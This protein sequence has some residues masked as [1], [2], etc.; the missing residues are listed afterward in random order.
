M[1]L[2]VLEVLD[3]GRQSGDVVVQVDPAFDV[4]PANLRN[5]RE[6][7]LR[8]VFGW[9]TVAQRTL[10]RIALHYRSPDYGGELRLSTRE[11]E[12]TCSTITNV[13]ITETTVEETIMLDF[14]IAKAGIR[15]VS[16]LLPASMKDARL[17]VPLLGHKTIEPVSSQPLAPIRVRLHLQDEVMG[18]LRVLVEDDHLLTPGTHHVAIPVVETG[19]TKHRYVALESAGRDEVVIEEA[20]GLEALTRNQKEWRV[21]ADMLGDGLTQ[22]YVAGAGEPRLAFSTKKRVAVKTAGARIGLAE[23]ILVLDEHGTYRATQYY[24]IDN[25]KEQ[26]LE[27][28]LPVGGELWSVLVASR[29]V[30][31]AKVPGAAG[32]RNVRIPLIK[33]A[34]G[35]LDYLVALKY[36]G[37]LPP[38]GGLRAVSFPFPRAVNVPVELSQAQLFL[39]E[40]YHWF[41]FGGTLRYVRNEGSLAAGHLRYHTRQVDRLLQTMQ[42]DSPFARVRAAANLQ[43]VKSNMGWLGE[44]TLDYSHDPNVQ[45]ELRSNSLMFRRVDKQLEEFAKGP[46]LDLSEEDN[47]ERLNVLYG[48][49]QTRRARNQVQDLAANFD[50]VQRG[51]PPEVQEA[52]QPQAP[53]VAQGHVKDEL[54]RSAGRGKKS[55]AR[56]GGTDERVRQYQQQLQQ[57][58]PESSAARR[59]A[60]YSFPRQDESSTLEEKPPPID[61]SIADLDRP[62]VGGRRFSLR[63]T[64]GLASLA[65]EFPIRGTLHCFTTPRGDVSITVRAVHRHLTKTLERIGLVLLA[66]LILAALYRVQRGGHLRIFAGPTGSTILIVAGLAGFLIGILPVVALASVVAGVCFKIQVR[67]TARAP[68]AA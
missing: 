65:V 35:D 58:R 1:P 34:P 24:R 10:A 56:R 66:T 64:T 38:P 13:R 32:L 43:S 22:A 16:F 45:Q 7:G 18:S 61:G 51:Q 33:T 57:S 63:E 30:K 54:A 27:V 68:T 29:P 53:E 12:V 14:S 9:V 11:P 17:T 25:T 23:T 28:E 36:G 26:F 40:N 19:R 8:Q 50:D 6:I 37:Q 2:P 48:K 52:G 67:R 47:R 21:L 55:R 5:C 46:Q 39:P 59:G 20:A 60:E 4:V 49:Q 3:A 42:S 15:S 41:D 44:Y 62:G 31:P